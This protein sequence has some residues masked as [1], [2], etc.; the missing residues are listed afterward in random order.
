MSASPE[1]HRLVAPFKSSLVHKAPSGKYG[2][3]VG[4]EV[5]T[6]KLLAVCGPFDMHVVEIIRGDY[7]WDNKA[8]NRCEMKNV[9]Q[10]VVLRL[11]ITIDGKTVD[12]EEV[13]DVENPANWN[14]E[15]ARLKDAVSDA[16]K[17]C[18]M[19]LGVGIHL[20]CKDRDSF[21]IANVLA[22]REEA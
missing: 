19:R 20:W 10:A 5:V 2:S 13:G 8:G 21:F 11:T 17:R 22:G 9:V 18:A 7:I 1:L 12:V 16:V 3:Y 15:G 14:T 4:H 6:Q